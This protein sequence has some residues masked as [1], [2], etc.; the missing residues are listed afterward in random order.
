MTN[1]TAFSVS[2]QD[3]ISGEG[4]AHCRSHCT[5]KDWWLCNPYPADTERHEF[6]QL[7]FESEAE[8]MGSEGADW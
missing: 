8:R 5:K 3:R 6:W 2:E 1:K 7:G 4:S